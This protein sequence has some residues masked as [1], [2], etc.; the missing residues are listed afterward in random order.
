MVATIRGNLYE[1]K[2]M[3]DT[4]KYLS[5]DKQHRNQKQQVSS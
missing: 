2:L 1:S 3:F 4:I 5:D